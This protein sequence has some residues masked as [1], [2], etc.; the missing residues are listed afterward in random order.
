MNDAPD[1][2]LQKEPEIARPSRPHRR[3]F[4]P[5]IAVV[6]ILAVAVAAFFYLRREEAAS[7]SADGT[8]ST[9]ETVP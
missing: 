3:S 8:A 1:F 9:E 5:L 7:P 2:D 4:A 6:L